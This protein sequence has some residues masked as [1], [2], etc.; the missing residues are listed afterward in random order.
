MKKILF[1]GSLQPGGAEHQMVVIA[2]LL[3]KEGY[4]VTYMYGDSSDFYK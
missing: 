1:L 3:K 4:D 2:T